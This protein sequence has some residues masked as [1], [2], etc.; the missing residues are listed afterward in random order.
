VFFLVRNNG[1]FGGRSFPGYPL[2]LQLVGKFASAAGA[3]APLSAMSIPTLQQEVDVATL[4]ML[5]EYIINAYRPGDVILIAMSQSA[6]ICIGHQDLV[7]F[8]GGFLFRVLFGRGCRRCEMVDESRFPNAFSLGHLKKT[9]EK[10]FTFLPSP[11]QS[12]SIFLH[13]LNVVF[14]ETFICECSSL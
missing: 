7:I 4:N 6:S 11:R 3:P 1:V 12:P 9:M 5:T 2:E 13:C 10:Q 14:Q 8:L